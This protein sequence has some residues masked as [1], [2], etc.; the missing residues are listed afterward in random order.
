M[1]FSIRVN[2]EEVHSVD[3]DSRLVTG[4]HVYTPAGEA[5]A[6]GFGFS[7]DFLNIVLDVQSD[8]S[9]PVVEDNARLERAAW[10]E[11]NPE[12]LTYNENA[13]RIERER[14]AVEKASAGADSA[15]KGQRIEEARVNAAFGTE[16]NVVETDTEKST[17]TTKKEKVS[18]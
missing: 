14:E 4:V 13:A 10:R 16:S 5:S 1:G 17:S 7:D 6:A 11:E 18:S 3:V 9:L 15:D 12:T 8:T 2:G